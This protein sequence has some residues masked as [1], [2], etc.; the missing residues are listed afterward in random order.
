MA[1]LLHTT[2]TTQSIDHFYIIATAGH[3]GQHVSNRSKHEVQL[4]L[5][6]MSLGLT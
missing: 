2:N 5:I 1:L 6:G 3:P 4:R